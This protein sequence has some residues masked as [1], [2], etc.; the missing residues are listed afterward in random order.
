M[1]RI[2]YKLDKLS[3]EELGQLRDRAGITNPHNNWFGVGR[4]LD[5][6]LIN[7]LYT[8]RMEEEEAKAKATEETLQQVKM[9]AATAP[10]LQNRKEK[11]REKD[12]LGQELE[13]YTGATTRT[14]FELELL[15]GEC[16]LTHEGGAVVAAKIRVDE[17][18]EFEI[19]RRDGESRQRL[20]SINGGKAISFEF[21][22]PAE[23]GWLEIVRAADGELEPIPLP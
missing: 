12:A 11:E 18:G 19:Y 2:Y 21:L 20:R 4:S 8:A 13:Q 7:V 23:S 3:T 14:T 16:T 1:V 10:A 15:K 5:D 22:P 17:G 6:S 9:Y